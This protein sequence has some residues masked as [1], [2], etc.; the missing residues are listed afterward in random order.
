MAFEHPPVEGGPVITN[1]PGQFDIGRG[2][3]EFSRAPPSPSFFAL[4]FLKLVVHP[5][6]PA[7]LLWTLRH[8]VQVALEEYQELLFE[9]RTVVL[10]TVV[11][12]RQCV[13]A[14]MKDDWSILGARRYSNYPLASVPVASSVVAISR[15][16]RPQVWTS[17]VLVVGEDLPH[18]FQAFVQVQLRPFLGLADANVFPLVEYLR[19]LVGEGHLPVLPRA[20][21]V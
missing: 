18:Q 13:G 16:Q 8:E 6:Q 17:L 3:F 14:L 9:G 5:L 12:V 15:L 1:S 20:D 11:P 10:G 21:V 4:M 7:P 19:L 2:H